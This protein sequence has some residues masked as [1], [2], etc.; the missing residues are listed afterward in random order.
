MLMTGKEPLLQSFQDEKTQIESRHKLEKKKLEGTQK[1][2]L[3]ALRAQLGEAQKETVKLR[4]ELADAEASASAA[5]EA[6]M[7]AESKAEA[8]TIQMALAE[9]REANAKHQA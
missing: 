8:A 5:S 2:A 9:E 7:A 3:D 4:Q 1:Q 6:A